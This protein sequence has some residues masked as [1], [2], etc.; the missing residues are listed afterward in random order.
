MY[1]NSNG[2]QLVHV[3]QHPTDPI[4][5][6]WDAG[7]TLPN[8]DYTIYHN[9]GWKTSYFNYVFEYIVSGK[10]Y[11]ESG[12]YKRTVSAGDFV[13]QNPGCRLIY[14][15]D[16]DD[17]FKKYFVAVRGELVKSLC[18]VYSLNENILIRKINLKEYF[19]KILSLLE[20]ESD[21][22]AS[23][24]EVSVLIHL[25]IRKVSLFTPVSQTKIYTIVERLCI[26]INNNIDLNLKLSDLASIINLSESQVTRLFNK[27]LEMSP[28]KYV[29]LCKI[30][31]AEYLLYMTKLSISQ[32]ANQ[33]NYSD[34]KNFSTAY[35]KVKGMSPTADREEYLK[36]RKYA[37]SDK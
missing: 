12:D 36:N 28:M 18:N 35:R 9:F 22:G 26:F 3:N 24:D 23:Y 8:P 2:E 25:I 19:E 6:V 11:I 29:Q 31:R 37:D 27:E 14:R 33:L 32:I 34:A 17:P 30:K 16:K 5:V 15:A 21:L 1:I 7:I 4:F 13:F 20:S 10:G